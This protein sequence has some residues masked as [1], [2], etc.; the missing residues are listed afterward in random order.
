VASP[1]K[2]NFPV[3]M[4]DVLFQIDPAP[5]GYKVSQLQA[6]LAAARQQAQILKSNY[7]QATASVTGLDAQVKYNAKRLEDIQK[8]YANGANTEFKEQD[9]Q[10]QLETVTAQLN[11]AKATQ[12]SAKLALDSEIEVSTPP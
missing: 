3:K 1:V 11:V 6:S 7:E 2:P 4:G 8:L 10:V 12:Q 9:T 5:Y